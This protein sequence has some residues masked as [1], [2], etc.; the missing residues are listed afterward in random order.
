[1][2]TRF[3]LL[4][5]F[6]MLT[7]PLLQGQTES[8]RYHPPYK[9]NLHVINADSLFMFWQWSNANNEY[10][11]AQMHFERENDVEGNIYAKTLIGACLIRLGRFDD[12]FQMLNSALEMARS[13]VNDDNPEIGRIYY[14]LGIYYLNRPNKDES[15]SL[16]AIQN[17]LRIRETGPDELGLAFSHELLGIYHRLMYEYQISKEH[18]QKSIAIFER[19]LETYDLRLGRAYRLYGLTLRKLIDTERALNHRLMALEIF[20]KYS[21]SPGI[22]VGWINENTANSYYDLER[23]EEAVQYYEVAIENMKQGPLGLLGAINPISNLAATYGFMGQFEKAK[24]LFESII[25]QNLKSPDTDYVLLTWSYE[26]YAELLLNNNQLALAID[27]VKKAIDINLKENGFY[28][29]YTS[30]LYQLM[31]QCYQANGEITQGLDHIQTAMRSLDR[32]FTSEDYFDSPSIS[33]PVNEY[34]LYQLI[35]TKAN[36]FNSLFDKTGDVELLKKSHETYLKMDSLGNEL[37]NELYSEYTKIELARSYKD[38]ATHSMIVSERLN[39]L[40]PHF[41]YKSAVFA[42]MEKNRYAKIYSNQSRVNQIKSTGLPDSL[43]DYESMLLSRIEEVR[44][45]LGLE[46]RSLKRDSLAELV[47]E[48][49]REYESFQNIIEEK[50]PNYFMVNYGE[51]IALNEIQTRLDPITQIIEYFWADSILFALSFTQKES[52]LRKIPLTDSLKMNLNW[53]LKRIAAKRL[54][55][56]DLYVDMGYQTFANVGTYLFNEL[57]EPLLFRRMKRIIISQDGLLSFLPFEALVSESSPNTWRNAPYLIRE[58]DFQYTYSSNLLFGGTDLDVKSDPHILAMA[59]SQHE[60]SELNDAL[61]MYNDVFR[62]ELVEIPGSSFEVDAIEDLF[63]L[64]IFKVFKGE[65]ATET[66]FKSNAA[67]YDIIHLATHGFGGIEDLGS[68]LHFKSEN[69]QENDGRLFSYEL[70]DLDMHKVRLAVMSGCESG[71]G[72]EMRGEGIFSVARG[73]AYAGCRSTVMSLWNVKDKM[74]AKLMRSFYANLKKGIPI[75][76]S[77]GRAKIEYMESAEIDI[78]ASPYYWSGFIF[79]G[80]S[81]PVVSRTDR[82]TWWVAVLS[83]V[84]LLFGVWVFKKRIMA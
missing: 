74:T 5:L 24:E 54:D 3:S 34:S 32:S 35:A 2:N 78:Q 55:S 56:D 71:I 25:E 8:N 7:I 81:K 63:D 44:S 51:M 49:E 15:K 39:Q 42:Q 48:I 46:I 45:E 59:Y 50:Y 36:L 40:E 11:K 16:E 66:V 6:L 30:S 33:N 28:D 82:S 75:H 79:S 72:K 43:Y 62:N 37:R 1:M 58:Y 77:L 22:E 52:I 76:K 47:F 31:A 73:F 61:S 27:F 69:D 41:E 13:K 14:Y 53:F 80:E 38:D 12:A 60:N 65:N 17:S 70:Y 29:S 67:K 83:I 23:F 20:D 10:K 9:N 84:F 64:G 26:L 21:Q 18:H 68:S 19:H 4:V 57:L